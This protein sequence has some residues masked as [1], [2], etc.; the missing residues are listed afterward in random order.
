M[1]FVPEAD[2]TF[3]TGAL[4][5][6]WLMHLSFKKLYIL[7]ITNLTSFNEQY[8]SSYICI[9]KHN[10]IWISGKYPKHVLF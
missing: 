3:S 9:V 7:K 10:T 4:W 5:R 6:Q 8:H 2:G 1:I